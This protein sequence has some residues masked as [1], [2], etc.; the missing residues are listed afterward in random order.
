MEVKICSHQTNSSPRTSASPK[1][2]PSI[3]DRDEI[4]ENLGRIRLPSI[5]YEQISN[6]KVYDTFFG[7]I[8]VNVKAAIKVKKVSDFGIEKDISERML[9]ASFTF[10]PSSW[11]SR[12][13]VW[14]LAIQQNTSSTGYAFNIQPR[15]SSIISYKSPIFESC[16]K[17]DTMSVIRLLRNGQAS[18]HDIDEWGRG[19]MHVGWFT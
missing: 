6:R 5:Q 12:P 13:A 7:G 1:S 9:N 4:L 8:E 19:L 15:Y 14:S 2:V 17:G 11:L 3:E 10:K 16:R 18:V